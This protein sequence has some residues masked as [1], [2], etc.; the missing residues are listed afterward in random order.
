[1][2]I[3]PLAFR[4][5]WDALEPIVDWKVDDVYDREKC[6]RGG[7]CPE[8]IRQCVLSIRDSY[9]G[10]VPDWMESETTSLGLSGS[11]RGGQ[12]IIEV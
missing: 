12:T 5:F 8:N 10:D 7:G 9:G 6:W 11:L 4:A 1:M 3:G 2:A